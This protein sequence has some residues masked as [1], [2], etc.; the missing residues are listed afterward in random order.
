MDRTR[1]QKLREAIDH[2]KSASVIV[3]TVCDAETDCM[4]NVPENLQYSDRYEKMEQA[5]QT[6]S[7]DIRDRGR[8]VIGRF[9][10]V[11]PDIAP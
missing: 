8:I 9:V 2:L 7:P 5:V 10:A 1:R 6:P 3:D 11:Q 4:D